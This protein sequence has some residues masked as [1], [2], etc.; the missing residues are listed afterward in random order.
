M[1]TWEGEYLSIL[2]E[3]LTAP[4]RPLR[5]SKATPAR[6][7][8]GRTIRV[9]LRGG[10]IPLPTTKKLNYKACFD[11]LLWMLRGETN[12]SGLKSRI[13]DQW[14]DENGELGPVYGKQWRAWDGHDQIAELLDRLEADPF[15][16]RH[17]VSTWNV[18]ELPE[19][20]LP[21]CLYSFQMDVDDTWGIRTVVTQRSADM[22]VGV[23]FNLLAMATLTH[24]IA[25][26]MRL[27]TGNYQWHGRELIWNGANCHVYLD[28]I[29]GVEE[30]LGRIADTLPKSDP[31]LIIFPSLT[32]LLDRLDQ[33]FLRVTEYNP[34][35]PI[36]FPVAK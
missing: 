17:V 11:E 12:T 26:E 6:A 25:E 36:R 14:A 2:Q 31:K 13:W 29:R 27:R 23:P 34:L 35:G 30:Q 24:L 22:P 21:P 32:P 33:D 3:L 7:V 15:S 28:Q 9:D 5:N 10:R 1:N 4:T 20:A 8:T 19:M 16:T 18:G